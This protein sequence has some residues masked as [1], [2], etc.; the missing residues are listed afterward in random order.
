[1]PHVP[2]AAPRRILQCPVLGTRYPLLFRLNEKKLNAI[3][4][5]HSMSN[6]ENIVQVFHNILESYNK[7]ARKRFADDVIIQAEGFYLVWR[8][9]T[10]LKLF[11]PAFVRRLKKRSFRI[12][13]GR[14]QGYKGSDLH[15]NHFS[16]VDVPGIF[17][18]T[19][20]DSKAAGRDTVISVI[21]TT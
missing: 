6:E 15:M 16:V 7:V 21:T 3:E 17:R 11:S 20:G 2:V 19:S 13:L 9:D 5:N 8:P 14:T 18:K 1:M 12:L 4:L 10:S